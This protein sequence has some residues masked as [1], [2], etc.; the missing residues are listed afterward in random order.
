M[1]TPIETKKCPECN[2]T[3]VKRTDGVLITCGKC[4]G[5]GVVPK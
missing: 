4:G 3:G 1:S 5:N 2:G